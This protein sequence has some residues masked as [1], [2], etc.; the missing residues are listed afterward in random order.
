[1]KHLLFPAQ[2]EL[3]EIAYVALHHPTASLPPAQLRQHGKMLDVFETAG[4]SHKERGRLLRKGER[5]AFVL[6]D[7]QLT[8]LKQLTESFPWNVAKSREV[9]RLLDLIDA[10]PEYVPKDSK[11]RRAGRAGRTGRT[12]KT[13][14]KAGT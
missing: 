3:Y 1:M 4:V 11:P 9:V 7:A 5:A 12:T 10:A 8:L 2:S 6:E 14:A 13:T